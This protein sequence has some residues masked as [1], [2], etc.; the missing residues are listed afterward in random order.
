M[1]Q[2]AACSLLTRL[3]F[4]GRTAAGSSWARQHSLTVI[5]RLTALRHLEAPHIGM[6]AVL[7]LSALRGLSRLTCLSLPPCGFQVRAFLTSI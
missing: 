4:N 7:E 1:A 5:R 6:L 3:V 2:L